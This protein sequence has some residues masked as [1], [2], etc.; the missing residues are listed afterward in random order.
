MSAQTVSV[1]VV[2]G[3][4]TDRFLCG[5]DRAETGCL[6][7]LL[8]QLGDC[9]ALVGELNVV[10]S[11]RGKTGAASVGYVSNGG[12]EQPIPADLKAV[13]VGTWLR[14]RL[15]SWARLLWEDNAPR[16]ADGSVPQIDLTPGIIPVSR[17]LLRHP[18]WI[19]LHPAVDEM[20]RELMEDMAAA[21]RVANYSSSAVHF[22][23]V[24]YAVFEGVE[25]TE[26]LF[27]H[28][29]A[30]TAVCKVC[31]AEHENIAAR[32]ADLV[33]AAEN[34]FV[35]LGDLVGLVTEKGH[36]L[37]TSMLR[38]LRARG[39]VTAFVAVE[40]GVLREFG[41]GDEGRERYYQ[42]REVLDAITTKRYARTVKAA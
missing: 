39:R 13:E 11:K 30:R 3:A 2:C 8:R 32:R 5:D 41:P 10:L 14:D 20:Y 19:A 24:C 29:D 4:Q 23:G 31:G 40:D 7:R 21:W 27:A 37:T 22:V 18:T 28:E 16:E 17:W 1:C 12:D 15:C 34:E 33:T 25:C 26:R 38:N 9:A 36:R 35:P 42:V 6:G